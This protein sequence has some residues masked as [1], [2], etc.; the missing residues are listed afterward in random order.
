[1][2][3]PALDIDALD[4][5]PRPLGKVIVVM[6]AYNAAATLER[7]FRDIPRDVV[8][9][10]LLVDDVSR[11]QTVALARSLGID[12]IVREK[13]GG[14]G[15]NQKTCYAEA[16]RR[17]ADIVVMLHPDYQYDGRVI[18]A[19]VRFL[20]LGT[21]D[22]VLGSRIRTR[23]EALGGGMP[24]WKYLSNRALTF[25][26]NLVMGQNIGDAH[27]G[28]RAYTR[29]VLETVPFEGNS[30]D[31]VF[32]SQFLSQ[33]AYFGFRIGDVPVPTRYFKQAS[34]IVFWRS[35][36]YGVSTLATMARFLLQ[37]WGLARFAM[38]RKKA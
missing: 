8:D 38:Y 3:H 18:D 11:D 25:T 17:G 2:A 4:V 26:E 21:C 19:M 36:Q 7:T 22:V 29:E 14:Y 37:T 15:A 6:P 31:F 32:D 34:S 12:T 1:V 16:L 33:V 35:V 24:W 30:D 13:N 10:V 23:K 9:D 5:R 27:T 20:R 28:L